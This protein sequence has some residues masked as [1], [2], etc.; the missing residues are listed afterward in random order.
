[1]LFK[2]SKKR[3]GLLHLGTFAGAEWYRM[4][5]FGENT[6]ERY[7]AY[8]NL[9]TQYE[10]L[11]LKLSDLKHFTDKCI[12]LS[13]QNLHK[14]VHTHLTLLKSYIELE[15]N[16]LIIFE[17]C[18]CFILVND[19]PFDKFSFEHTDLKRKLYKDSDQVKVFFCELYNILQNKPEA[20][21]NGLKIWEYIKSRM[22]LVTETAFLQLISKAN[23]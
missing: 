17:L 18:Q 10:E 12:D 7:L 20:Y 21:A 22:A 1:M 13:N 3:E 11:R 8:M 9:L 19:E 5:T 6:T 14:E 15:N 4:A 2:R 23:F 16:N